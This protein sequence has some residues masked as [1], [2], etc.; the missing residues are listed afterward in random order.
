MA[1]TF[2]RRYLERA[3]EDKADKLDKHRFLVQTKTIEDEDYEKI[4]SATAEQ[5]IDA[6]STIQYSAL[7]SRVEQPAALFKSFN[8]IANI[9]MKP[10]NV[11]ILSYDIHVYEI[12]R[13]TCVYGMAPQKT[14]GKI[15]N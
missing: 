8:S 2:H 4:V 9:T 6:V 7:H 3:A 1:L 10:L 15:L 5:R 13:S 12:Y 14:K 11:L